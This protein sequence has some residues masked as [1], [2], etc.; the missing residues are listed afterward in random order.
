MERT[1]SK[2][3]LLGVLEEMFQPMKPRRQRDD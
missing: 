1:G 2:I 3:I